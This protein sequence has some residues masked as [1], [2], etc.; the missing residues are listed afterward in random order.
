MASPALCPLPISA[1]SVMPGSPSCSEPQLPCEVQLLVTTPPSL[2][3]G[4]AGG[5]L[6]VVC[7]CGV[8]T[9]PLSRWDIEAPRDQTGL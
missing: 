2:P 7:R 9:S 3:E 5:H 1:F 4:S 8:I 6:G